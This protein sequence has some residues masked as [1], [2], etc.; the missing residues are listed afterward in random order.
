M[1]KDSFLP[2]QEQHISVWGPGYFK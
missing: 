2:E 1:K